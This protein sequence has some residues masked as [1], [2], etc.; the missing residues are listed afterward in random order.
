MTGI[1][2][3]LGGLLAY[4]LVKGFMKGL[5][6]ELASL[7][8]LIAGIYA[9]LKFSGYAGKFF[10]GHLPDDPKHAAIIAFI[11]TFIAVVVSIM[12]LAKAFTK[13][14]DFTG[15]GLMNRILGAFFGFLR[16]VL[17]LSVL[18]NFFLKFNHN[19]AFAKK[20]TLEKSVL[21]YPI[22]SVSETI[23]PVLEEWF[24]AYKAE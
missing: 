18:L 14:A 24:A 1:D 11:I 15:L 3:V 6:V 22:L 7:V 17:T 13:L 16:M 2:I 8:S 21:F 9:A 5:F 12:L 10:D 23:F 19:S 4:G 20:E